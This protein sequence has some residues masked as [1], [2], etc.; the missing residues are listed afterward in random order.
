MLGDSTGIW[1]FECPVSDLEPKL[2]ELQAKSVI[3][4]EECAYLLMQ[5]HQLSKITDTNDAGVSPIFHNGVTLI[6]KHEL[7]EIVVNRQDERIDHVTQLPLRVSLM[8]QIGM[9]LEEVP[10]GLSATFILELDEFSNINDSLGHAVGDLILY[11]IGQRLL[12]F[13]LFP[14]KVARLHGDEFALAVTKLDSVEDIWTIV[15][16]LLEQFS[17][18]FEQ[19]EGCVYV[20]PSIGIAHTFAVEKSAQILL[21]RAYVALNHAKQDRLNAAM[22]YVPTQEQTL[23]RNVYLESQLK[24]ALGREDE[25]QVWYQPKLCLKS[26]KID[27][28]EALIRWFHPQDGFIGPGEFIPLAEKSNLICDVSNYVL[29]QVGK[30]IARFRQYGFAGKVSINFSAND[31]SKRDVVTNLLNQ[32]QASGLACQDIEIELT[33][34]A[35]ITDFNYCVNTLSELKKANIALSIDDFGTGYSSLSYLSQLPVDTIKIDMSF[36]RNLVASPQAVKIYRGMIDI[37]K[38]MS[39]EVLAEG[40]DD[41]KQLEILREIGCDRIQGYLLSKPINGDAFVAFIQNFTVLSKA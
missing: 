14:F 18:P 26:N 16:W 7:V 6:Q 32:L 29:K 21:E 30:D 34:G 36:V 31:F 2:R 39:F 28:L 37:C 15:A 22:V 4:P 5:R 19:G 8:R 24:Q 13:N 33:E 9:W 12:T 41:H 1:Y 3:Y 40:V 20:T 17:H 27:G 23:Q 11:E 38:A 25:L 10:D 35:F